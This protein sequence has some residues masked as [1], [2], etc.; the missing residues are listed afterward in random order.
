M[1]HFNLAALAF[2]GLFAFTSAFGQATD[3][4]ISGTVLDASGAAVPN[5]SITAENLGTSVK[6]TAKADSGGNYRIEHLLVGTYS[7]TASA[8][9]FTTT[10]IDRVAIELNKITTIN[11]KLQVGNVSTVVE[12]SETAAAIDTSTAQVQN[13]F[14]SQFAA[15]LPSAA[16]LRGGVFNLALLGSGVGTLGGVGVGEGPSVGGQRPRNNNFT[17]EGVDNNRKDVTGPV[18][19]IPND[20]VAEFTVLQNQFSA[21]YGHSSGGQFNTVLYTGTNQVHGALWEYLDN[22]NLN[23]HDIL[24]SRPF[25]NSNTTVPQNPRYDWNRLGARMGGHIIKNKLF[26]FGSYEYEPLGQASVSTPIFAPTAAGYTALSGIPNVSQTNLGILKQ[27]LPA[28]PTQGTGA[29]ATRTVAGVTVPIGIVPVA[30]PNFQNTYRYLVSVDYNLS[31]RDQLRA[32]YIDNKI[33]SIDTSAALPIFFTARPTTSHIGSFSEFHTFTPSVANEFRLAYNRYN[34]NITV[35]DFSWPGLDVFPNIQITDLSNL[36]LGPNPNGPQGTIQ[37]TYQLI[38]NVSWVKGKHSLKFGIDA[39][40]LIAASTFIQ[41]ERGDYDYSTMER[42]LLDKFPDVLAE[43]NVGGKPYSGNQT[44]FYAFANDN[45][46]VTPHFTL[47]LGVRYEFN[48]V[49]QSMQEFDLNSFASVPGLITFK[50]PTSQKKNF[51]PRIGFAYSP[52]SSAKTSIRAGFGIAYDQIFDNVGTNARPP[53]ATATIDSVPPANDA[54][55]SGYLKAGGILPNSVPASLNQAQARAATSSYLPDQK[56]GYSPSWNVGI[57]HVFANDF[58]FEA[59]Y[60]GNRGIHLLFQNQINRS[61]LVT[62]THS[63]PLF[64]SAPSQAVLDS[65]TLTQAQLTTIRSNQG[66]NTFFPAGF[67]STI[68]GYIPVGNSS[69]HGLALDLTKRFAK[70]YLFKTAYTFSHLI[71]DST[72]EVNSTALTPR[73]P[74]DFQ[75]LTVERANSAL[76]RRQRF[77]YTW[78]YEAPWFSGDTNWFKKNIIG[79]YQ[80]AGTYTYESGEFATPQSGVDSNLNGDSAGDRTIINPNGVKNT[81]S[82][83]KALTNSSGAVVGYL[84]LNPNAEYIK[85]QIGMYANGGRNTLQAPGI[86]SFDISMMKAFTVRER[87]KFELRVDLFNALNHPQYTS[88]YI[89]NVRSIS[90]AGINSMLIPGNAFFNMFDQVFTNNPRN[91]QVGAKFVF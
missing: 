32:R 10:T 89:N 66:N 6:A 29:N 30:A 77:T 90:R 5:A 23:A 58:T 39:R 84:A 33:S 61:S 24:F 41:R 82:D 13:S 68:T 78:I 28:A 80:F 38:D 17:I 71:D 45:W 67:T 75:N 16:N 22:R 26:Y 50:A 72:A 9:G 1:R 83:V 37:S 21:E 60:L 8:T 31:D 57:Q 76:D 48:G 62:P 20:A 18:A 47:N 63:L 46:K 43:R 79:N 64:Y 42:F 88:G 25:L 49:A 86:N 2:C 56:V 40:D 59:R 74:Q 52:G 81:S 55:Y 73:R 70:H 53:Q 34:D 12:I 15:E 36:Q 35:P 91:V 3:G 44:A 4:N 87:G 19:R 7:I 54:T 69:Y 14:T 85:A 65:L 27:Y 51:A 11:I